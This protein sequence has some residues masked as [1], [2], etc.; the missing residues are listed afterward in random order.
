MLP[1]GNFKFK[2]NFYLR[3]IYLQAWTGWNSA[4]DKFE[5]RRRLLQRLRDTLGRGG[6]TRI[7]RGINRE[8]N[9]VSRLLAPSDNK[10]QKNIG[11]DLVEALD[12][13]FPGWQSEEGWSPERKL[14]V[15][16]SKHKVSA[17]E[18]WQQLYPD[19]RTAI[20]AIIANVVAGVTTL[21]NTTQRER[22]R[23]EQSEVL[24]PPTRDHAGIQDPD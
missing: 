13:A 12:S 18:G 10:H 14:P 2:D 22:A 15:V 5:R 23:L 19:E 8:T 9:Y 20:E 3:V 24:N 1:V 21:P 11:D 16:A 7:A 6:V 4:M 17:P